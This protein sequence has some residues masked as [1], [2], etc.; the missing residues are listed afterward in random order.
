VLRNDEHTTLTVDGVSQSKASRGKE[1]QFGKFA[2]NSDIFVGG[3]PNW[4]N[5]KLALLALPSV[6]FEPRFRGSVRNLVY[7]DQPGVLPRRQEMRQPRDVKV[8]SLS[9]IYINTLIFSLLSSDKISLTLT[10]FMSFFLHEILF[11]LSV[12]ILPVIMLICLRKKSL[13]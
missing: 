8:S 5:A 10:V 3:M 6:I 4:Y 11:I 7:T 2:T 1:F 9:K 13:V 12:E